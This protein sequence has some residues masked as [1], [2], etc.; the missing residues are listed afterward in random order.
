M[1]NDVKY[2][3]KQLYNTYEI[4]I[5]KISYCFSSQLKVLAIALVCGGFDLQSST[6]ASMFFLCPPPVPVDDLNDDDN[7]ARTTKPV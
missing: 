1:S 2:V 4:I 3:K 5:I 6:F 7:E